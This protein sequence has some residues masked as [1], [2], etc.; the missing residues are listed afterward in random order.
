MVLFVL[1]C[2]VKCPNFRASASQTSVD[3]AEAARHLD[4][5]VDD[6]Q[7]APGVLRS[8]DRMVDKESPD[9]S[10]NQK[11]PPIIKLPERLGAP[12]RGDQHMALDVTITESF[13]Q[14][15]QVP[16]RSNSRGICE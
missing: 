9:F 12:V 11:L 1:D 14:C 15:S 16:S 8:Q 10:E 7:W 4:R 5:H 2:D 3:P 13:L 6:W